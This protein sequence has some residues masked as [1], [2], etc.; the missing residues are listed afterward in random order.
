MIEWLLKGT[1]AHRPFS[2]IK[3]DFMFKLFA[4]S[5]LAGIKEKVNFHK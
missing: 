3:S 2:A 1:S 5:K 4:N